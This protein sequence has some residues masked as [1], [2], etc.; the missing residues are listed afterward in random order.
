MKKIQ[1]NTLMKVPLIVAISTMG[2]MGGVT[3]HSKGFYVTPLNTESFK[4]DTVDLMGGNVVENRFDIGIGKKFHLLRTYNSNHRDKKYSFGNFTHNYDKKINQK[5]AYKKEHIA[6]SLKNNPKIA[7]EQGWEEIAPNVYLGKL[8]GLHAVFDKINKLCNVYD[9]YNNLKTTLVVKNKKSKQAISNNLKLLQKPD[10]TEVLFYKQKDGSWANALNAP[11]GFSEVDDGYKLVLDNGDIEIYGYDGR[12]EQIQSE[13]KMYTLFYKKD[14]LISVVDNFQHEM[15]FIYN[16]RGFIK[17]I[18]SY[19]GTITLYKYN[20]NKQLNKV[21]YPDKRTER[22]VY[23]ESKLVEVYRDDILVHSYTYDDK[24]RVDTLAGI[25][26]SNPKNITYD[27]SAIEVEENGNVSTYNFLITHSQA[28]IDAVVDD[29]NIAVTYAYDDNAQLL[30]VTDTLGVTRITEYD[31]NGLLKKEIDNAGT[32]KEIKIQTQYDEALRK[33]T[34]IEKSDKVTYHVYDDKG[35]VAYKV[36][37]L[38]DDNGAVIQ[39]KIEHTQ[40]NDQGLVKAVEAGESKQKMDYDARGNTVKVEDHLGGIEKVTAY[41]KADLPVQSVDSDG[42]VTQI[43]YDVTGKVLEQKKD[44]KT[45]STMKYDKQ[46]RLITQ[47]SADGVVSEFKYD[48]FGNI[49]ETTDSSGERATYVYDDQNNLTLTQKYLHG[50]LIYKHAKEYDD[51]HRVIA[52]IDAYGKRMTYTYNTKGQKVQM[53]DAKGRSIHYEYDEIGK[54]AKVIDPNGGETNY[55]YDVKGHIT[56]VVTPNG[57]TFTYKYDGFGRLVEESNP[58]RGL[59]TYVYDAYDKLLSQ[60]NTMIKSKT[61]TNAK[62]DAKRNNYDELGR[63]TST[64]YDDSS[65]NVYYTYNNKSELVKVTDASGSTSVIYDHENLL[66]QT[67]TIG[68]MDF[69]TAYTYTD[70]GKKASM[71]Y[72]SG[73]KLSYVYNGKNEITNINLDGVTLLQNIKLKNGSITSYGYVDGGKHTRE[74]DLNERLIKLSYPAYVE[75]LDYDEVSNI[76]SIV[77]DKNENQYNYDMLNRLTTYDNNATD[78]QYFTYDENGNRLSMQKAIDNMTNYIYQANTNILESLHNNKEGDSNYIYDDSGNI[79]NDG[80]HTYGYDGRNRLVSVDSN[81]QYEYNYENQRVSKTVDGV[82]TYYVYDGHKLLG[83]YDQKGNAIKE[84]IYLEDTPI[85]VVSKEK[86]Y[87]IYTDHLDTARRVVDNDG[88]VVWSWESSPYGE[89]LPKGSFTLN[90]RFPGQYYDTETGHHYNINRDYN[91]VTGR[92]IQSD[93]IGFKGGVNTYAYAEANPVMK[94]DE[95]GLWASGLGGFFKLHQYVNNRVFGHTWKTRIFNTT[96]VDVDRQQAK[97]K[98]YLH[99]MRGY[100]P[101]SWAILKATNHVRSGFGMARYYINRGDGRRAYSTLGW[102]LHT[103]QDST[104]PAHKY[105]KVW[106][107]YSWYEWGMVLHARQES[108]TSQLNRGMWNST[109]WVWHMFYY[110]LVPNPGQIFIF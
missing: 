108:L 35:K 11:L 15:Q 76:I 21:I 57:A 16:K 18:I 36:D 72:P 12:L 6:S 64:E 62:G 87:M 38:V 104:S 50:K 54:L 47:T 79:I 99:A 1:I 105:F 97:S 55:E 110:R 46:G 107:G 17:K 30:A 75:E 94:K 33:P 52:E 31:K 39:N 10:G 42:K 2:L 44:G 48:D 8:E 34:I 25:K 71:T 80:S 65:L 20:K 93:P 89:S 58:D 29:E 74:Y 85:A 77:T 103:L 32:D 24:G 51:K 7:C 37:T 90:L 106:R 81:V 40:Y 95:M 14:K 86:T 26:G 3:S 13:E 96:T 9:E 63:I 60:T 67:Q 19:D 27:K 73:S 102:V 88:T 56:N 22:Y 61:K 23:D 100:E 69:S 84:Y 28:K 101:Q 92:Y 78:Y 4:F 98:S 83:E 53:T 49:V 91:P 41:N 43:R 59:T 45:T 82:T 5:R 66:S 70:A 68:T 109:R